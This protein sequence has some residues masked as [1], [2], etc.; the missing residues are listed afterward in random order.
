M[1]DLL[2]AD[3]TTAQHDAAA[4][5]KLRLEKASE[6][7]KAK[8]LEEWRAKDAAMKAAAAKTPATKPAAKTDATA[9]GRLKAF[10]IQYLGLDGNEPVRI[11][12]EIE[13]GVGSP[14]AKLTDEQRAQYAAL[15]KLVAAEAAF[16]AAN[17][18]RSQAE[19]DCKV[20][21]REVDAAKVKADASA[22]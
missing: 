17:A 12:G 11:N 13:R 9:L 7:E 3:Q 18:A 22:K 8:A 1:S 2:T 15:E 4:A 16:A 5:E 19:A 14:F 21:A 10:E 6:A 20:A